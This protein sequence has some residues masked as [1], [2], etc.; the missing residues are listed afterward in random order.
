M[1]S[2]LH[3]DFSDV[4]EIAPD[5]EG[6]D[7]ARVTSRARF[8]AQLAAA[9]PVTA[10]R[11][12][13]GRG[14]V[15]IAA[16][17]V[18]ALLVAG[19]TTL[20]LTRDGNDTVE[21]EEADSSP[22]ESVPTPAPTDPSQE[23]SV[24]GT[25][26][27]SS[28]NAT[29][30][31][32]ARSTGS[33]TATAS[34]TQ[35][36]TVNISMPKPLGPVTSA[37]WTTID[38]PR[39]GSFSVTLAPGVPQKV[40][41]GGVGTVPSGVKAISVSIEYSDTPT[42]SK[43]WAYPG[44]TKRPQHPTMQLESLQSGESARTKRDH[45]LELNA[46]GTMML[47]ADGATTITARVSRFQRDG[48][49]NVFSF[50]SRESSFDVASQLGTACLFSKDSVVCTLPSGVKL[51]PRPAQCD[52]STWGAF[53]VLSTGRDPQLRCAAGDPGFGVGMP[54]RSQRATIYGP[55]GLR[56][57]VAGERLT[58]TAGGGRSMQIDAKGFQLVGKN[59]VVQSG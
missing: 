9:H 23:P 22:T 40:R 35:S 49:S 56:C 26:T 46:D 38:A 30:E 17:A 3:E 43:V 11:K 19:S 10:S 21:L 28:T 53:G 1:P 39:N 5:V 8:N 25:T 7:A 27:S 15:I 51:P 34:S 20:L 32:S 6:L 16:A 37:E 57:E 29:D 12:G 55:N 54:I 48:N 45:Y 50:Q 18:A 14:R 24:S 42:A 58:C 4:A 59:G 2:P 52:A 31:P 13:S 47:E 41:V 44:G 33:A 36:P